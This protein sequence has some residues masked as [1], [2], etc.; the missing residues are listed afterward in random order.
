MP[1]GWVI[2]H[3]EPDFIVYLDLRVQTEESNLRDALAHVERSRT[4]EQETYTFI[5]ADGYQTEYRIGEH[6]VF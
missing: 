4:P 2:E 6:P 1:S 5:E 3:D